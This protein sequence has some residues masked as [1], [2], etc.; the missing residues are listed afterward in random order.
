MEQAKQLP[1]GLFLP[2]G[3]R[4]VLL[5]HAYTGS[6]N[7]VRM[8]ARS[9][10]S[11]EY[12]VYAPLFKGHGTKD[13]NDILIQ[14]PAAWWQDT[15]QALAFLRNK[16]YRQIAVFG[17]SMGGLYAMAALRE[18]DVLGGGAFC[19][20]LHPAP[21]TIHVNFMLYARHLLKETI[22]EPAVEAASV[23]QLAA[24]ETFSARVQQILSDIHVPVF[25]AQAGKDQLISPNTVYQAAQNLSQ[26]RC[27]VQW[28]PNSGHV[29]TVGPDRKELEKDVLYFIEGLSW[30]EEK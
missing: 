3:K 23:K 9:L 6:Y 2:K 12:T 19:S 28:Y 30:N 4:A 10:E 21:N 26:T 18:S 8:L 14:S 7:D 25:L 29:I 5:L 13:P 20:P 16:G 11:Q 27:N 22:N 24:I 17:L 1:T 15:Q